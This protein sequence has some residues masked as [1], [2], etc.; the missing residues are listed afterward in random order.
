[1]SQ[2]SEHRGG[3]GGSASGR[4]PQW[5]QDSERAPRARAARGRAGG[6]P[7]GDRDSGTTGRF[8]RVGSS[9]SK[10]KGVVGSRLGEGRRQGLPRGGIPRQAGLTVD[11]N[12]LDSDARRNRSA[13]AGKA[14]KVVV[15]VVGVVLA[16][17]VVLLV[18]L[19]ILSNTPAFTIDTVEAVDSA[20]VDADS[21]VRL[22]KVENGAT[23]LNVDTKAIEENLQKNPWILSATITR[24]FPDTLKIEVTERQPQYLVVMGTGNLGWYLGSDNV[25]IEP[26]R[27]ETSGDQSVTDAALSLAQDAGAIVITGVPSTV[28]P[29]AGYACTD[30]EILTVESFQN[31]FSDDFKAQIASYAAPDTN[32]VSCV[33]TD[34]IEVSLGAATNVDAKETVIKQILQDYEG[35]I[36]YLNVRVPSSPSYRGIKGDDLSSGTGATGTSTDGGSSYSSTVADANGTVASDGSNASDGTSSSGSAS[37]SASASN[38]SGSTSSASGTSSGSSSGGNTAST[39]TLNGSTGTSSSGSSTGTTSGSIAA[40]A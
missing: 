40:G 21:I 33:L 20:H 28:S 14:L 5:L 4:T 3:A 19:T 15:T 31:Q 36:T 10:R 39:G 26:K 9:G 2:R 27:I 6:S 23:L 22:A 25:W 38:G 18:G 13:G 35:Q 37:S 11:K 16:L 7:S 12:A 34:G 29:V 30:S 24:E 17:V 32:G 8:P 1:M